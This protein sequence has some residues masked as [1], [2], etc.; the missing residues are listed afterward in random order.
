VGRSNLA[1][2]AGSIVGHYRTV[3]LTGL[4]T[5]MAA[6]APIVAI[7]MAPA[8]AQPSSIYLRALIQRLS[9]RAQVVTPFT[10]AQELSLSAFIARNWSA[11]DTG[12]TVLT[13]T[14]PNAMLN[15]ISDTAPQLSIQVAGAGALTAGTR[16]L[17]ANPF[18][19]VAGAQTSA[20][21]SLTGPFGALA[22]EFLI[23]SDQEYGINLQGTL[24]P[25]QSLGNQFGPEGIVVQSNIAQGAGGT[26]R[27]AVEIEWV[28]YNAQTGPQVAG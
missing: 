11:A 15:S 4:T 3:A 26:V 5:G 19:Y 22:D 2:L 20:A 8:A 6:N 14:S 25:W 16:T 23:N 28:E 7:R 13:L 21:A 9:I 17:D 27:V 10:A 18:L 24:V 1:F 12:G